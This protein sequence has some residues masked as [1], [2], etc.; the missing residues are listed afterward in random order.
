MAGL[1]GD[2]DD[3]LPTRGGLDDEDAAL[4]A[5]LI[6][7]LKGAAT[8][9]EDTSADGLA[10]P[11]DPIDAKRDMVSLE[12]G[13]DTL[14]KARHGEAPK[15]DTSIDA[16]IAAKPADDA[17]PAPGVAPT[18][19]AV[20]PD[21]D[22]SALLE[23]VPDDRKQVLTERLTAGSGV[24]DLFK[25]REAELAIHGPD[26]TPAKA[27]ERLLYLNDFAQ[28][29]PAEYLAWVAQQTGGAEAHTVLTDAAKHL[30]YKLV[31][32]VDEDDDEFEDVEKKALKARLKAL[33]APAVAIGPDAPQ[34]VA[35]MQ[36]NR[37][38]TG[39]RNAVGSDGQPLHPLHAN[40]TREIAAKVV[41]FRAENGDKIPTAQ[42]LSRFY[43]EVVPGGVQPAP[44]PSPA[45]APAAAPRTPAAP[46]QTFAAQPP[47]AVPEKA[48]TAVR[49]DR[50]E[51]ASKMLDGSGPGSDRRPALTGLSGDALL[52]AQLQES[53]NATK[54]R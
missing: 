1:N 12:E 53:L 36:I 45:A 30:G 39:F 10:A 33:E 28:A 47:S 6:E 16:Q 23:G 37:A 2:D 5:E 34:N 26:V 44:A 31:P 29:N 22:F 3:D 18:P 14:D 51:A 8:I 49:P 50:S 38:L 20:A 11:L 40:F 24:L 4:K 7:M 17:A 15:P 42:D 41:A 54:S 32:D 48:Q 21:V 46:T 13:L 27:V 35:A 19:A 25:G 52:K 43:F 9:E